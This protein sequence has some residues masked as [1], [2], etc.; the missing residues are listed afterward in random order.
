M[1]QPSRG[2]SARPVIQMWRLA[3]GSQRFRGAKLGVGRRC[4]S[5]EGRGACLSVPNTALCH[6]SPLFRAYSS[7]YLQADSALL[8]VKIAHPMSSFGN[9]QLTSLPPSYPPHSTTQNK[10]QAELIVQLR[11]EAQ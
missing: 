1:T 5:M 7:A 2:R 10:H 8:I 3:Q 4:E 11:Q 6:L 9:T